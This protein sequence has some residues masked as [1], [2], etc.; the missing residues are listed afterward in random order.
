[1]RDPTSYVLEWID[2]GARWIGKFDKSKQCGVAIPG[3]QDPSLVPLSGSN[4]KTTINHVFISF[5][6][7]Q[8]WSFTYSFSF[9]SSMGILQTHNVTQ[10]LDGLLA[11]KG[12]MLSTLGVRSFSVAAPKLWNGQPVELCQATSLDCF[13]SRL[14][15]Y[16]FK[17]YFYNV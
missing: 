7:E 6:A 5:S 16:L 14:K 8:T 10:L 4:A 9:F 15:S 12:K 13:K 3:Y 17:K 11:P 2:T 1:M